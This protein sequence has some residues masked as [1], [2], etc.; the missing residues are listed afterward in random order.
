MFKRLKYTAGVVGALAALGLGGAAIAGATGSSPTKAATT[1]AAPEVTGQPDGDNI[2]SGDQTTPDTVSAGRADTPTAGDKTNAAAAGHA[3]AAAT[4]PT[5]ATTE[6]AAESPATESG[7]TRRPTPTTAPAVT[8]TSRATPTPTPSS[9]GRTEP[10]PG[11][12]TR[13]AG[14]T[15]PRAARA[16]C[17]SRCPHPSGR[18]SPR[19]RVPP[20]S[21]W[22]RALY[23]GAMIGSPSARQATNPPTTSVASR[24]RRRS[25]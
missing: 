6:T 21:R 15:L 20:T 16:A 10:R 5:A 24:P 14:P 11:T 23:G 1:V 4:A 9:K 22:V 18:D 7:T 2:Q 19:H 12:G 3:A 13:L 25:V 8:P 17:G